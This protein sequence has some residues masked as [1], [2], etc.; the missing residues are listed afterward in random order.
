MAELLGTRKVTWDGRW[1][2]VEGRGTPNIYIYICKKEAERFSLK[3]WDHQDWMGEGR[4]EA[5]V[6]LYEV[7]KRK[8]GNMNQETKVKIIAL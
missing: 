4:Q 8:S 6:Q 3:E 1:G 7:A 5:P 2:Q